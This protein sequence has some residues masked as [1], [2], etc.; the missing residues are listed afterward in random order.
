MQTQAD[1]D[2]QVA[3]GSA[4]LRIVGWCLAVGLLAL[5]GYYRRLLA[6]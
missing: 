5:F 3:K 4:R 1:D 2:T 6:H